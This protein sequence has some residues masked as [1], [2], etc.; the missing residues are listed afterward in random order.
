MAAGDEG[1]RVEQPVADD[2]ARVVHPH[3][4]AAHY[5]ADTGSA[6]PTVCAPLNRLQTIPL[7]NKLYYRISQLNICDTKSL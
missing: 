4:A 6:F 1:F 7:I 3:G 2:G 5:A